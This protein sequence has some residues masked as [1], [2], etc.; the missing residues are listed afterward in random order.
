MSEQL[1]RRVAKWL[2][3]PALATDVWLAASF[4]VLVVLSALIVLS[5]S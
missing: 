2:R 1:E 4:F 3:K 5:D